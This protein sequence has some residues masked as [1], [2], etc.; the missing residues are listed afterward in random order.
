[1]TANRPIRPELARR[2]EAPVWAPPI[3]LCADNGAM[4]AA[5]GFFVADRG[6][7]GLDLDVRASWSLA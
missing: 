7:A 6:A 2:S 1:V 3:P 4:I 5:A